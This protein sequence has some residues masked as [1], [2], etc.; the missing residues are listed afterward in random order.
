[1]RPDVPGGSVALR[2][3]PGSP[4]GAVRL[5]A[6]RVAGQP[7]AVRIG[8]SGTASVAEAAAGLRLGG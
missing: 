6:M 5:S 3:P 7:F 2:P 8:R 1:V 4:V